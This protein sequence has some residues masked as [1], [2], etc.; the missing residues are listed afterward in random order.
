M[1]NINYYILRIIEK[2]PFIQI[3]VYNSIDKFNFLFPHEKDYF[4]LIKIFKNFTPKGDFIDVGGNI[5]LSIIGFRKLGFKNPIHVFE[6]D[7]YCFNRLQTL[8]KKNKKIYC[9][10]FGLGEKNVKSYLYQAK[11]FGLF[12]HFLSSFDI[13]Y[14][15]NTLKDF[16]GIF[17]SLFTIDKKLFSIKKFDNLK[18]IFNPIFIKIDTEGYDYLVIRGML[19]TIKKFK[20][21]ILVE[22]NKEN[23]LQ[24][25]NLLK[26]NYFFYFYNNENNCLKKINIQLIKN[27]SKTKSRKSD[28]VSPRNIYLIRKNF[29][30]NDSIIK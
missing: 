3:V 8:K 17:G 23:I 4:G 1:L 10:N 18:T 15:K 25:V 20:P 13:N 7:T 21:V 29:C 16:Y 24:I 28:L 11:F 14:L 6:P 26:K 5:G 2:I 9:Y 27:L 22:F 19:T 12:F 30:L